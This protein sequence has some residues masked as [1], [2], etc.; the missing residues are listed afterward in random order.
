MKTNQPPTPCTSLVYWPHHSYSLIYLPD[1]RRE[2]LRQIGLD[3][4]RGALTVG[5]AWQLTLDIA[6]KTSR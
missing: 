3:L 5:A 4:I 1:Q 2:A 6:H